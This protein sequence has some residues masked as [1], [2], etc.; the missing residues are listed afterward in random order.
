[1][2]TVEILKNRDDPYRKVLQNI[3]RAIGYGN[4]QS[5]LGELWDNMLSDTYGHSSV[6]GAMGVTIDDALPPLPK[7][8]TLR[9]KQQTDGGYHT[10]QS[11]SVEDMKAYA[12]AAIVKA[13]TE[14]ESNAVCKKGTAK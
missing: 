14:P 10:V 9:R 11:Y 12:R 3:G 8:T 2:D 7:A 6:R 13:L 5:I 1:M 4:A